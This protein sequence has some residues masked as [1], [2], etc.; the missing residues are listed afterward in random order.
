MNTAPIPN[1]DQVI[2][3]QLQDVKDLLLELRDR[4]PPPPEERY[5]SVRETAEFLGC[6]EQYVYRLKDKLPHY[7]RVGKLKFR[8]SDLVVFMEAGREE[9]RR[10]QR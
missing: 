10:K 4:E 3:D 2:F 7:K 1:N 8:M 9:P 5:L 6:D